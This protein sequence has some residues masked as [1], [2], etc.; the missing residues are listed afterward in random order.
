MALKS[1]CGALLI[2]CAVGGGLRRVDE[3]P[4]GTLK[5]EVDAPKG[6]RVKRC[7]YV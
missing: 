2:A 1:F 5:V 6:V 4:D 7:A 3:N